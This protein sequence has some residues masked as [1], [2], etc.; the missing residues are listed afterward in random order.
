MEAFKTRPV[1]ELSINKLDSSSDKVVDKWHE[2]FG[3]YL[4]YFISKRDSKW[5]K[6]QSI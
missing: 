3:K 1:E 5:N 4:S 2:M 6:H